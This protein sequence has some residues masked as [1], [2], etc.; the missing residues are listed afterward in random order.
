MTEESNLEGR[1][2]AEVERIRD[3][4]FGPQM[5]TYEQQFKRLMSQIDVQGKQLEEL[6]SALEQQR[7][8][9]ESRTRELQQETVQRFTEAEQ[10]FSSQLG[11]LEARVEKQGSD[12]TALTRQTAEDLRKEFTTAVDALEDD[13]ASRDSVGDLLV[14]MGTRL[15]QQAGISDLLGQLEGVTQNP[16]EE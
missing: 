15:K 7:T 9:Q 2:V 5:R 10:S 12:V 8:N 11:Q 13:K 1:P 6:R 16:S 14:E 4:I 3:I